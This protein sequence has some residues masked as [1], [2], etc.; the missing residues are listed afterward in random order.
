MS[1]DAIRWSQFTQN[2]FPENGAKSVDLRLL[3]SE[4]FCVLADPE[5]KFWV[6]YGLI[7]LVIE[8][9]VGVD[10]FHQLLALHFL[11]RSFVSQL[12]IGQET[13]LD[14]LFDSLVRLKQIN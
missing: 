8:V 4:Y 1:R 14:E 10:D 12:R 13:L 9:M 2:S 3:F 5:L 11:F 6:Y 7:L